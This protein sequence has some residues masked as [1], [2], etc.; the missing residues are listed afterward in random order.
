M[1]KLFPL[2]RLGVLGSG[3]RLDPNLVRSIVH[4]VREIREILSMLVEVL[5]IRRL[6]TSDIRAICVLVLAL[7]TCILAST[8]A[9]RLGSRTV[10]GPNFGADF[11]GF[12]I[13]GLTYN[14]HPAGSIYDHEAQR[15]TYARLFPDDKTQAYLP[16]THAPFLIAPLSQLARLNYPVAYFLWIVISVG[17]YL[18]GFLFLR[19]SLKAIPKE[20]QTT[21]LLLA[22]SFMPFLLECVAGGQTSAL[23]FFSIAAAIGLERRNRMIL[24]GMS[25]ALCCYQPNL[26]LLIVPMLV[27][28]R[29]IKTIDGFL[30]GTALAAI[31][32]MLLVGAEGCIE[33]LKTL[34]PIT[35]GSGETGYK[36]WKYVDAHS[37]AKLLGE[38]NDNI[39]LI[40][41][42]AVLLLVLSLFVRF[43]RGAERKSK[44]YQSLLWSATITWTLVA[45]LSIGIYDT[46]L[47]VIGAL[48][49][50]HVFFSR[51]G[52]EPNPLPVTY[53][54]ILFLVYLT[55]W[56]TQPI[57]RLMGFQLFTPVLALLGVYQ[58]YLL[59]KMNTPPAAASD[60]AS[61]S[62]SLAAG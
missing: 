12:Y 3:E 4:K 18:Q 27:F 45:N 36:L 57:A 6:N 21:S 44:N 10:F 51:S 60:A 5:L 11:G 29:R 59:W 49:T 26:L 35:H 9:V 43:W 42:I 50:A 24:S 53:Q 7:F 8:F 40:L 19:G 58:F 22:L 39:N 38:P 41:P 1:A 52:Q 33:Y 56:I 15:V 32:S 54:I 61:E 37:F 23:G 47:A 31:V 30:I 34:R 25:L 14:E 16:Y 28:T 20:T 46:A 62:P 48:L 17:L 55:P 13:A 2:R